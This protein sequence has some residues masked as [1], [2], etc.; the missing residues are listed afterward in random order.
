MEEKIRLRIA[1]I[2]KLVPEMNKQLAGLQDQVNKATQ[3]MVEMKGEYDGLKKLL[4]VK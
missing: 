4:E 2:E 1:E 3:V